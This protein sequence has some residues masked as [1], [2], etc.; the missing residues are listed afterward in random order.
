VI[1][2][3]KFGGGLVPD[4]RAFGGKASQQGVDVGLAVMCPVWFGVASA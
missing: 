3:G 1:P 2:N 4:V